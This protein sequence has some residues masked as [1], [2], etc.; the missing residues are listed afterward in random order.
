MIK[1]VS[2]KSYLVMFPRSDSNKRLM[3][4]ESTV[5]YLVECLVPQAIFECCGRQAKIVMLLRNPIDRFV[6]NFQMRVRLGSIEMYMQVA[7]F[8]QHE[9]LHFT[10][11]VPAKLYSQDLHHGWT[12]IRCKFPSSESMIYEGTYYIHLRLRCTIR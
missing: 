1:K 9:I 3:T 2:W 10:N 12:S 8:V 11:R 4:G 5:A 7:D 6:S